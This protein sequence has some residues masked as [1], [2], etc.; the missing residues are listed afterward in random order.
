MIKPPYTCEG[1]YENSSESMHLDDAKVPNFPVFCDARGVYSSTDTPRLYGDFGAATG[2]VVVDRDKPIIFPNITEKYL[3]YTPDGKFVI[4]TAGIYYATFCVMTDYFVANWQG[5]DFYFCDFESTAVQTYTVN[6]GESASPYDTVKGATT[7]SLFFNAK[8]GDIVSGLWNSQES[9]VTIF[10]SRQYSTTQITTHFYVEMMPSV[11][12]TYPVPKEPDVAGWSSRRPMYAGFDDPTPQT[13]KTKNLVVTSEVSDL[14]AGVSIRP[15]G[16][17]FSKKKVAEQTVRG[18]RNI[19]KTSQAKYSCTYT[20][21]PVAI[22]DVI[23][24]YS[25]AEVFPTIESE[26][27]PTTDVFSISTDASSKRR[28]V[29]FAVNGKFMVNLRW[30][31]KI[32]FPQGITFWNILL[33]FFE[34]ILKVF[35]PNNEQLVTA[36]YPHYCGMLSCDL[37]R[38]GGGRG[39]VYP[40]LN[41]IID[42]TNINWGRSSL[43]FMISSS[44]QSRSFDF[45]IFLDFLKNTGKINDKYLNPTLA[46]NEN[47][48]DQDFTIQNKLEIL[49]NRL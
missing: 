6:S 26:V 49:V 2:T 44:A 32:K 12:A 48:P 4:P 15:D 27:P 35:L 23:S 18:L 16:V 1:L 9:S 22:G 46:R 10:K 40:Y 17:Y 42:T 20:P 24:T 21:L 41:Q 25:K 14:G 43:I 31:V 34:N 47:F 38:G 11:P 19:L 36:V 37:L 39:D 3:H 8:S 7:G 13:I 45:G 5:K 29:T 28:R 30:M 33:G